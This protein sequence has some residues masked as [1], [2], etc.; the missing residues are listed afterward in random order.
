[1]LILNFI[2]ESNHVFSLPSYCFILLHTTSYTSLML[3]VK[4]EN[5]VKMRGHNEFSHTGASKIYRWE[6]VLP[7]HRQLVSV[8]QHFT[9]DGSSDSQAEMITYEHIHTTSTYL[10][11]QIVV[12]LKCETKMMMI[13]RQ[14][15][16]CHSSFYIFK[17]LSICST[18]SWLL[19]S[20]LL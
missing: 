7:M 12:V 15:R 5:I 13:S 16:K 17:T 3:A 18:S 10:C 1:M 4:I 6:L 2:V 9:S 20:L 11:W 14:Q 19:W 8:L